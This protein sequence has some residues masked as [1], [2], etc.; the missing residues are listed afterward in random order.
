MAR[1]APA[2]SLGRSTGRTQH[3]TRGPTLT[4][5]TPL[6]NYGLKIQTDRQT[7]TPRDQG[8]SGIRI[9]WRGLGSDTTSGDVVKKEEKKKLAA[10]DGETTS[11][12][13]NSRREYFASRRS[14]P[15]AMLSNERKKR[16]LCIRGEIIP[17]GAAC[18]AIQ[19]SRR[20]VKFQAANR[21]WE[22][23]SLDSPSPLLAE[24]MPMRKENGRGRA[25]VPLRVICA[26]SSLPGGM[27]GIASIGSDG[28][29]RV[30]VSSVPF[31][32]WYG[33]LSEMPCA[34]LGR[35]AVHLCNLTLGLWGPP[36]QKREEPVR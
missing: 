20:R 14:P 25:G 35:V 16:T 30:R 32:I 18:A 9:S 15:L 1:S 31:G 34:A 8:P 3:V 26:A 29:Q 11:P 22:L 28:P 13:A 17:G 27:Y 19:G 23:G 21:L 6:P 5:A 24:P 33:S 7:D 2:W 36:G 10:W 12:N 4:P